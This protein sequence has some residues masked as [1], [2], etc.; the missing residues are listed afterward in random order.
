M[1]RFIPLANFIVWFP[2]WHITA[3]KCNV[4]I[5]K[6][7][8]RVAIVYF[9]ILLIICLPASFLHDVATPTQKLAITLIQ[10]YLAGLGFSF[11][12]VWDQQKMLNEHEQNKW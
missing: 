8:F 12:S 3:R 4:N 7:L 2:C 5:T 10:V 9:A 1:L 11:V 6:H